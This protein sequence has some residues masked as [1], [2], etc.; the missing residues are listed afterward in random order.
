[1]KV[2]MTSVV[3]AHITPA[4]KRDLEEWAAED[5]VS[6]SACFRRIIAEHLIGKGWKPSPE[7][8][9][10]IFGARRLRVVNAG[11]VYLIRCGEVFKIGR[12]KNLGRRLAQM[13]LPHKPRIVFWR[14]YADP[15]RVEVALH[16]LFDHRRLNGEWFSLSEDEVMR[17]K[18]FMAEAE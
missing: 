18:V 12:S 6:V 15:G 11:S 14:W 3:K 9:R 2:R 17:A 13:S 10:A 8:H 5:G 4:R 1:V 16:Q 7:E